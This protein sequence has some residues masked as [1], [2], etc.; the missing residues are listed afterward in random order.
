MADP[1]DIDEE[2]Q[3]LLNLHYLVRLD[4]GFRITF[5]GPFSD[6]GSSTLGS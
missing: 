3:R 5:V 1:A 6:S 2:G 4:E